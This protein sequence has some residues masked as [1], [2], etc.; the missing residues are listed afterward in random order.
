MEYQICSAV[1]PGGRAAAD[2]QRKKHQKDPGKGA[3]NSSQTFIL[4]RV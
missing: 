2:D 4:T 3:A 1:T